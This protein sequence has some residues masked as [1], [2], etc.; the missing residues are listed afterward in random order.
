MNPFDW[1]NNPLLLLFVMPIIA[2]CIGLGIH[3]GHSL[4]SVVLSMAVIFVVGIYFYIRKENRT[5][6]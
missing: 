4:L 5:K 3:L 1:K 6:K 2:L